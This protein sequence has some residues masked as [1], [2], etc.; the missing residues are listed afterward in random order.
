MRTRLPMQGVRV[1]S[2][3]RE[4][5]KLEQLSPGTAATEPSRGCRLQ[6]LTPHA[7]T[8]EPGARAPRQERPPQ[9][10]ARLPQLEKAVELNKDPVQSKINNFLKIQTYMCV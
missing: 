7:A 2:L 6:L 5:S 9:S 8:A 10:E 3:V 1:Q 4:A